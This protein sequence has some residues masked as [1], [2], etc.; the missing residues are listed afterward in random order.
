M[1]GRESEGWRV[2]DLSPYDG[3]TCRSGH[4]DRPPY[5]CYLGVLR[6]GKVVGESLTPVETST[7]K[8]GSVVVG[9]VSVKDTDDPSSVNKG[10]TFVNDGCGHKREPS[11]ANQLFCYGSIYK[12][13]VF[14][15]K[16]KN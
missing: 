1:D 6:G 12:R 10:K 3:K 2:R 16:L 11:V 8:T 7:T 13:D 15:G 14:L 9:F 5:P 4:S